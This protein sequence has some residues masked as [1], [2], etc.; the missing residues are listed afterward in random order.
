MS[1]VSG[2]EG[3]GGMGARTALV[4]VEGGDVG[5]REVELGDVYLLPGGI[6]PLGEREGLACEGSVV[7]HLDG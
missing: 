1:K 5:L 6:P 4:R 3:G 2:R 7:D